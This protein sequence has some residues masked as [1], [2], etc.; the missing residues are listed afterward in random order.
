M[1]SEPSGIAKISK[2]YR[3]A[4]LLIGLLCLGAPLAIDAANARQW[5]SAPWWILAGG[6]CLV[7]PGYYALLSAVLGCGVRDYSKKQKAL[8]NFAQGLINAGLV[9][10]IA[11]FGFLMILS[12]LKHYGIKE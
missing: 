2:A 7:I 8:S 11:L 5:I 10:L 9:V 3:R 6:T 1:P 4:L 12:H